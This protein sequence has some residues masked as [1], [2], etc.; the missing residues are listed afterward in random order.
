MGT[1]AQLKR[2]VVDKLLAQEDY[3]LLVINPMIEG[4]ALP[5]P[6]MEAR[7][8]VPIHIGYNMVIPIPDLEVNDQQISGTLS[9]D[10]A[11]FHCVFPW[12][13]VMQVSVDDE[14]LV[15]VVPVDDGILPDP[16]DEEDKRKKP[17]LRLV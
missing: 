12:S 14:H 3:V 9:F 10:R 17:H 2:V 8:P 4:V 7:Q 6:F 15:W 13:S 16:P 1:I 11:P 5:S